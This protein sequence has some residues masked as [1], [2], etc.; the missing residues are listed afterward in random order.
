MAV[1]PSPALPRSPF[2]LRRPARCPQCSWGMEER[3]A[4]GAG[5]REP[6]GPPR[7]VPCFSVSVDQDNILPGALRLIR[8]LRPHWRPEQVRTKVA[9]R[10][11]ARPR[12][13][14]FPG[15]AQRGRGAAWR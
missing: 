5:C 3:A 13:G 8:E 11:R 4:A 9:A 10:A 12:W 15:A 14:I 6:P 1:P 7:A 2:Y